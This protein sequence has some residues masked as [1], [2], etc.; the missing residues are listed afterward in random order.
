LPKKGGITMEGGKRRFNIKYTMIFQK[1]IFN[2]LIISTILLNHTIT[3]AG[4]TCYPSNPAFLHQPPSDFP[5]TKLVK[6]KSFEQLEKDYGLVFPPFEEWEPFIQTYDI[7]SRD[8]RMNT[9]TSS[10][11]H[12]PRII[13]FKDPVSVFGMFVENFGDIEVKAD[14]KF[15]VTFTDGTTDSCVFFDPYPTHVER[16]NPIENK[17]FRFFGVSSGKPMEKIIFSYV[18]DNKDGFR[19]WGLRIAD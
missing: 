18:D 3:H 10:Q 17:W 14:A 4:L 7:Y 5:Q 9:I 1:I 8:I 6:I 15:E 12:L 19:I 16:N 11:S 13:E 2:L